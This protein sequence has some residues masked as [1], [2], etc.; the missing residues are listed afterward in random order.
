MFYYSSHSQTFTYQNTLTPAQLVQDV[1][2]GTGVVASNITFNGTAANAN[3]IQTAGQTFSATGFPFANGVYLKTA[4]ASVITDPDLSAIASGNP[5]NGAILEFDF[6]AVGDSLVF[7]YVF[8]SSEY[9]GYTCSS[10]NDAFGF[11][12]SGPG[13]SGPYTNGAVN[14]ALVPGGNIPVT[15]NT[16]NSGV[17]SG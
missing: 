11:F 2:I 4:G 17:P 16:V 1:L 13:L 9:T 12:L 14:L 6:V 15:I 5:T 3:S 10:F 8:A 7:N